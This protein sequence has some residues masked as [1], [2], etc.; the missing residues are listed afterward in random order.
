LPFTVL[1]V[2]GSQPGTIRLSTR[3]GAATVPTPLPSNGLVG[4]GG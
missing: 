4:C 3:A 1:V 2:D